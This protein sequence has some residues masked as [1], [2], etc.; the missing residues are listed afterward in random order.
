MPKQQTADVLDEDEL[1]VVPVSKPKKIL[2]F[3]FLDI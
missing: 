2:S 1:L 3:D